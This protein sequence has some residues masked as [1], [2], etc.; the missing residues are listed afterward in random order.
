MSFITNIG[1]SII[2]GGAIKKGLKSIGKLAGKAI[3][4]LKRGGVRATR[5]VKSG[6]AQVRALPKAVSEGAAF[7]S[8]LP[9][10]FGTGNTLR[11]LQNSISRDLAKASKTALNKDALERLSARMAKVATS[12]KQ[13]SALRNILKNARANETYG[14]YLARMGNRA[15]NLVRGLVREGGENLIIDKTATTLAKAA[16]GL[17]TAAGGAAIGV[18]VAGGKNK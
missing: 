18:K 9:K 17:A 8:T 2:R 15:G 7:V 14:A 1:K 16:A 12:Q 6:A 3:K 11:V 5:G 13:S 4:G 10:G